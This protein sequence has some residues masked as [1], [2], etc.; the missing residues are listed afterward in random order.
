MYIDVP[1]DSA[2]VDRLRY[3]MSDPVSR[4]SHL[5]LPRKAVA[6]RRRS[7]FTQQVRPDSSLVKSTVKGNSTIEGT[8]ASLVFFLKK[9]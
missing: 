9:K 2:E 1:S 3:D 8:P 4:V 6:S 5:F 7:I